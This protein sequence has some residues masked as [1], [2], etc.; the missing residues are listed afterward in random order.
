KLLLCQ[1]KFQSRFFQQNTKLESF[2]FLFPLFSLFCSS[3]AIF[4]VKDF[5]KSCDVTFFRFHTL[6]LFLMLFLSLLSVSFVFSSESHC[7]TQPNFLYQRKRI[8]YKYYFQ[9]LYG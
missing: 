1:T 9:A 7:P 8:F 4:F 5:V 6:L 2:K 3:S